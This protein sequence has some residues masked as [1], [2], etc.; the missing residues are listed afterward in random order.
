[1]EEAQPVPH[2]R[3]QVAEPGISRRSASGDAGGHASW[4]PAPVPGVR[5]TAPRPRPIRPWTLPGLAAKTL[6]AS[7]A[8]YERRPRPLTLSRLARLARPNLR[9]PVFLIGAARSGTTFLGG[10]VGA[11]P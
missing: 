8:F 3:P 1:D 9:R 6:G 7:L 2:E 10:C 11:L 5:S 4:Y